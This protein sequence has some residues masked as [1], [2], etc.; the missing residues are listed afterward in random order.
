MEALERVTYTLHPR[1]RQLVC[2]VA[3]EH[4]DTGASAALRY[5]LDEYARGRDVRNVYD[6]HRAGLLTTE[7]AADRLKELG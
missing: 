1:H 5:I 2:D 4:G 6:A 7:Q 3:A